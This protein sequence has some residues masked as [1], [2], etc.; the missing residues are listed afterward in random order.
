M[1]GLYFM[2]ETYIN[3][4]EYNKVILDSDY[5]DITTSNPI[6]VIGVKVKYSKEV[7]FFRPNTSDIAVFRQVFVQ[8]EYNYDYT[9]DSGHDIQYIID[10]G[11][12]IGYSTLWFAHKYPSAVIIAVEPDIENCSHLS[13]VKT[14]NAAIWDK[15]SEISLCLF[16]NDSGEPLEKWAYRTT[17]STS[18]QN[19]KVQA[20]SINDLIKKYKIPFVDIIKIDIEGAEKEVFDST[21]LA[22]IKKTNSIIIELHDRFKHGC[23]EALLNAVNKVFFSI[24]E[25]D[26]VCFLKRDAF[27]RYEEIE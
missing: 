8:G 1:S 13:N 24:Q 21:D 11:A 25:K 14:L 7:V 9:S 22:W 19:Q 17:E 16:D 20:Y 6:E 23:R 3:E 12:N 18:L 26:N 15:K 4:K 2:N 5:S 10:C 27:I